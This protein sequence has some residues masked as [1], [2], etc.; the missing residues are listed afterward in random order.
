M[1]YVANRAKAQILARQ[2]AVR[3]N[4][5]FEGKSYEKAYPIDFYYRLITPKSEKY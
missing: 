3:Y 4:K 2:M 1:R 5:L